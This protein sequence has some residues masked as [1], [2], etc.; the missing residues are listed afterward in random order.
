[1]DSMESPYFDIY[2]A[3]FRRIGLDMP[4][5]GNPLIGQVA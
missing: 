5:D 4:A 2:Y 1:M 3:I